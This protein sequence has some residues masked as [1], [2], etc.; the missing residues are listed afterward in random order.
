M[1]PSSPQ[2]RWAQRVI[3]WPQKLTVTEG[4]LAGQ[5]LK[6]VPF[7]RRFI[8]GVMRN[9]EAALTIARANGKTTLAAAFG[10][11]ALAGR[12]VASRGQI[13]LVGGVARP[14]ASRVRACELLPAADHR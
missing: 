13:V 2:D 3:R 4:S 14:G 7:Q 8:Y 5:P 9:H 12:L 1:S 10:V 11:A 6:L